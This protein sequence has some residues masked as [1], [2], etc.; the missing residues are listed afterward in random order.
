MERSWVRYGHAEREELLVRDRIAQG[1]QTRWI[2]LGGGE[3]CVQAI[4]VIGGT[5]RSSDQA[6]LAIWGR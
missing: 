3:R 6:R 5:E 4:G 2:D 1:G